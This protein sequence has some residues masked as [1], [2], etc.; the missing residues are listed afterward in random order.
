MREDITSIPPIAWKVCIEV[1]NRRGIT[2]ITLGDRRRG[3]EK[4]RL[5]RWEIW[6]KLRRKNPKVYTYQRIGEMF[7]YDHSTVS[8]GIAAHLKKGNRK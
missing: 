1:C 5:A 6:H 8:A 3:N 4:A 2:P 7:G